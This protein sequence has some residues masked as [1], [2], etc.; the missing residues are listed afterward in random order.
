M[1]TIGGGGGGS[2]LN[3]HITTVVVLQ[4]NNG[5]LM[6]YRDEQSQANGV[7]GLMNGES[8]DQPQ[9]LLAVQPENHLDP[10]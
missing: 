7:E 9:N 4:C 10:M 3:V 8:R 2:I 5:S 1:L 6:P